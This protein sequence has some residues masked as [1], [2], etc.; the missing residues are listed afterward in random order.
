M[1]NILSI[2]RLSRDLA[3]ASVTLTD[4]EARYLVDLY[5]QMQDYRIASDGQCRS[6]DQV[7]EKAAKAKCKSINGNSKDWESFIND[8]DIP[9][10][11]PHESLTFF[12]DN[13]RTLEGDIKKALAKYV[14]SKPIGQWLLSVCGIGPVIAAGLMANIDIKKAPTAG[15]IWNFAGLNPDI[16]WTKGQ[17]RPFNARLKTL[18]WKI[19]E[20]FVKTQK[21]K[22]DIYGHL[23]IERENYEKAKNEAGDYKEQAAIMY[24]ICKKKPNKMKSSRPYYEQ[25][26][27]SP[28]H[29]RSRAKRWAV[30]L[31]L[32]H[33][34]QVWWEMETGEKPPKPFA[35]AILGHAHEIP[36]PNWNVA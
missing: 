7:P 34:Q 18:C 36:A 20:S 30:K 13:F 12:A 32:S 3:N 26:V 33:L 6:I 23:L 21:L 24:E 29:I 9:E 17:K 16:K 2:T 25:G 28:S 22:Q 27:L 31:F 35:I 10:K 11:E 19:G 1:E 15:H 8:E 4:T 14:E 5:Y